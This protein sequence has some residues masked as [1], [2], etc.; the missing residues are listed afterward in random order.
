MPFDPAGLDHRSRWLGTEHQAGEGEG[1]RAKVSVKEAI[2]ECE[3]QTFCTAS[4]REQTSPA[5]SLQISQSVVPTLGN[6]IYKQRLF[7]ENQKTGF[8]HQDATAGTENR[9][10]NKRFSLC[11]PSTLGARPLFV[12]GDRP[13][14]CGASSN[15]PAPWISSR[16]M[17]RALSPPPTPNFDNRKCL[18]TLPHAEIGQK[19]PDCPRIEP[20]TLRH[21]QMRISIN[22]S[23]WT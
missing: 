22:A 1:G 3:G 13:V 19:I 23:T 7:S 20:V 8:R 9:S 18:Q 4:R 15:I 21:T 6:C 10:Q 2:S 11:V 16:Q 17:L 14:R 5:T 12:V